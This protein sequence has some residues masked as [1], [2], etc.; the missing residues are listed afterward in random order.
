LAGT[1]LLS[2]VSASLQ[3]PIPL[4]NDIGYCFS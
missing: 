1:I 3:I 4:S 2:M